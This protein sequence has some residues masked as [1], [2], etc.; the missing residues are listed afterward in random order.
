M[1]TTQ[2]QKLHIIDLNAR[3][4]NRD[5]DFDAH[6]SDQPKVRDK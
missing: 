3:D 1:H 6:K 2:F 5:E 4:T